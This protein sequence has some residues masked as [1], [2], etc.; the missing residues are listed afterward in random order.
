MFEKAPQDQVLQRPDV[1]SGLG[2]MHQDRCKSHKVTT[3]CG[4][5]LSL[6]LRYEK[7]RHDRKLSHG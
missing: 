6:A 7:L 2:A 1:P 4:C 5:S 3:K